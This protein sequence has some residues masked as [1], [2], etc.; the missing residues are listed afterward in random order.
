MGGEAWV[1]QRPEQVRAL[2]EAAAP[3][4]VGWIEP[5]GARRS[6]SCGPGFRGLKKAE[7]LKKRIDAEL[8]TG[9][10]QKDSRKLWADF[11]EEYERRVAGGLAPRTR[12][13]VA[14]ALGNFERIARPKRVSAVS[15]QTLGDFA[16]ARR[17]E[18]SH[19]TGGAVSPATV[20]KD[21]R[22]VKA[23]LRV[24]AEWGYLAAAPRVRMEKEPKRLPTYIPPDHFA[25]VYKA[26]GRA[27][28][29]E[30]SP[31]DWWRGLLVAGY[32]TG[33]RINQL[34]SLRREDVNLGA[35]E[36]FGRAEDGK[37]KRDVIVPLHPLVVEH[38]RRLAPAGLTFFP[39]PHCL[40]TLYAD[41]HAIQAEAG[42]KPDRKARYGFHDL[43][44]AFATM[45]ADKLS[46]DALQ[47]LMQHKDY[48]T[49]QR[50]INMARQ[51]RPAVEGLFVPDLGGDP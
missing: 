50:Y 34:L 35:G 25:A 6:K 28:R 33:W 37:G 40:G 30:G 9:A 5:G 12:G 47:A 31:A 36:A 13:E 20:N 2:G 14:A 18:V 11:R 45:N 32:M 39:W 46:P 43:R 44:R 19:V 7:A 3:H 17:Q 1:Y 22:H 15:A 27:A 16:A 8:M 42:V 48:Q 23:A 49:T 10:Y 29:P 41:F 51:L 21:L 24:A 38:L 26:C 4:Y